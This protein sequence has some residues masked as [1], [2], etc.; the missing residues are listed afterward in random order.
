MNVIDEKIEPPAFQ[1][2]SSNRSGLT[3]VNE[4]AELVRN[5]YELYST[6]TEVP[7]IEVRHVDFWDKTRD[8]IFSGIRQT[9]T[10][11]YWAAVGSV[12][13][14]VA[15]IAGAV[16]NVFL[17]QISLGSVPAKTSLELCKELSFM[18]SPTSQGAPS[19]S[20]LSSI[21]KI[22]MV[23]GLAFGMYYGIA[24]LVAKIRNKLPPI[25]KPIF[26]GN[27]ELD[28]ADIVA[29]TQAQRES[30]GFFQNIL[31]YGPPGTGKT[32]LSRW[33][34]ENS[35]MNYVLLTGGDFAQYISK[36]NHVGL[37]KDLFLKANASNT[38]T[39]IFIDE[40][41]SLCLTREKIDRS[42]LLE[43]FNAFLQLTG[44]ASKKV[45]LVLA[46]N[47][48]DLMDSAVL[49][50]MDYKLLIDLPKADE[51]EKIIKKY[52]PEFFEDHEAVF[53]ETLIEEIVEKTEGFSGRSLFKLI[54]QL[55]CVRAS[56]KDAFTS[57]VLYSAVDRFI[58]REQSS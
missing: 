36:G 58:N 15:T 19:T 2:F 20:H 37:M 49:S 45:Q 56:S 34:A 1:I 22:S 35:N 27:L 24:S 25:E 7:S 30:N 48:L 51:R 57:D 16:S 38:P 55:A 10:A 46:T 28:V 33:M 29:T 18:Y 39:V 13:F 4:L 50:R 9:T 23:F 43:L 26:Q 14:S 52:L 44:E 40:A 47:R 53:S 21:V 42:E 32:M 11:L 5:I 12:A 17:N 6:L 3:T 54:N 8:Q 31:L 41:E